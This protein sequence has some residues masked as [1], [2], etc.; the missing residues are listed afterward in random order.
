[1]SNNCPNG[2]CTLSLIF[3]SGVIVEA[4][5]IPLVAPLLLSGDAEVRE[6]AVW[7][8]GNVAG[9]C[10]EYRNRLL[11]HEQCMKAVVL[12]LEQPDRASLLRNF[13]WV[14]S[15]LVR[16]KPTPPLAAVKDLVLALCRL[17][18]KVTDKEALV[19]M[20][21]ALSYTSDGESE[22]I[23]LLVDEGVCG[24]LVNALKEVKDSSSTPL[25][26]PLLRTLGR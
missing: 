3:I 25:V 6:Q 8:L 9:D 20:F 13:A 21:W 14:A 18:K 22:R 12:N 23:S 15:N 16:G 17:I 2:E 10:V 7:C 26:T 1:M 11:E 4:G 24:T 5:I 19:D